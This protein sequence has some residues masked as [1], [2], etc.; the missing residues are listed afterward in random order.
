MATKE[1]EIKFG[2]FT[3][4]KVVILSKIAK[5]VWYLPSI[6][7]IKYYLFDLNICIDMIRSRLVVSIGKI[8][9]EFNLEYL[10]TQK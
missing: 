3:D 2:T 4:T 9:Q 5:T 1:L 6:L 10:L 8:C 7:I